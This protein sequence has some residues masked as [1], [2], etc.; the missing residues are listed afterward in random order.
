MDGKI[1]SIE[2][3]STVDGPGI[4]YVVFMQGCN[5]RCKFCH[6]PD[7]WCLET[8]NIITS[9]ELVDKILRAKVYFNQKGGVTFSG[10]EPLLQ[11][12]FLIEVCKKLKE[13]NIHI[14]LDTAGNFDKNNEKIIELLQYIDLVLFDIK[15][16]DKSIHKDLVGVENNKILELLKYIDEMKINTWIRVVYIPGITD[17]NDNI[18]KLKVLINNL[19]F[20]QKV[21]FL[22]YHEMGKYKWDELKLKYHLEDFR[23]S[24]DEECQKI[25][26]YLNDELKNHNI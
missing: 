17:Q 13:N 22:P 20:V 15:H 8:K 18:E 4:R 14:T 26:M 23:V 3:F 19:N 5:L 7:T 11:A 24:T 21:E 6:N 25:E 2:S 10:G 12:E 16:L 1:H 9:D